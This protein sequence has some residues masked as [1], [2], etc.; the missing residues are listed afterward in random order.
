MAKIKVATL[1]AKL[2]KAAGIPDNDPNLIDALSITAEVDD[3]LTNAIE[4]NPNSITLEA[5]KSHPDLLKHFNAKIFNGMDAKIHS[6][7]EDGSLEEADVNE[8]KGE[9]S[10]YEKLKLLKDKIVASAAKK[11]QTPADKQKLVDEITELNKQIAKVR[12]DAKKQVDLEKANFETKLLEYADDNI[13]GSFDY[14]LADVPKE[15]MT[16]TAKQIIRSELAAKKAHLTRNDKGELVLKNADNPDLD[17]LENNKSKSYR[18]LVAETL[19]NKKLL[20]VSDPAAGNKASP[21]QRT[22]TTEKK[23][24]NSKAIDANAKHLAD[25]GVT[26]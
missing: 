16:A 20:K 25:L 26:S 11:N 15:V 4:N 19:A 13:L 9:K 23:F 1:I 7:I 12:D 2:A 24:D 18:D 21:A 17:Y 22:T 8:I 5:A 6:L 3:T 10:S 14:A